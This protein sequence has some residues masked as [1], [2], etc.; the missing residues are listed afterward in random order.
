[1]LIMISYKSFAQSA[2]GIGLSYGAN[3]PF[4]N[5][6]NFGSGVQ[7]FGNLAIANNWELVPGIG[8]ES[9]NSKGRV[10]QIDSYNTRH[11]DNIS[12]IYLGIS[13]KYDFNH[14]FF[15]KAGPTLYV[16]GGGDDIAAAGIGGTVAGGYNWDLDEHSTLEL[17][18]FTTVV[19][20]KP[21]GNGTTPVAGF[22]IGYVFNFRERR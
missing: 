12:L 7:L 19:S 22:K 17:S 1:M 13:T 6:Y 3:K 20:I 4:S 9:L 10:Y 21:S 11:I 14:Q 8:L 15:I 16:G 5:D 18:F 2:S